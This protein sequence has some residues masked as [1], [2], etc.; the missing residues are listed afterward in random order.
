M[1]TVGSRQRRP[2][3]TTRPAPM[4]TRATRVVIA[5]FGVLAG[6]AAI[7]H[8]IGEISQGSRRPATLIIE[9][10]PD[11][12]AFAVLGG[13]PALIVM[14]NLLLSGVLTVITALA[15]AIWSVAFVQRRG[16]GL[17]LIL[18]SVVLL[19][20]GGGLAPP[21]IGLIL[22]V[23]ADTMHAV[24]SRKSRRFLLPLARAWQWILAVG[25]I[26][27]LAL[28][29]GT[30]FLYYFGG[31]ANETVVYAL[32]FISFSALIL[33]LVGARAADRLVEPAD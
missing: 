7:E 10:W 31:V 1:S 24:P 4:E 17:V 16:G 3:R 20:V 8:G 21:L 2:A 28:V 23:A 33:S 32:M 18:L 25:V 15:L 12:A 19:L 11:T 30:V 26:G 5:I 22:G 29:P 6:L 14:P 13:E 9:S 27:Y